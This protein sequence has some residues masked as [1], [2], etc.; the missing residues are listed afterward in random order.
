[1]EGKTLDQLL[2]DVTLGIA[3]LAVIA[4][5]KSEADA[6]RTNSLCCIDYSATDQKFKLFR[7]KLKSSL[8][9]LVQHAQEP[10]NEL[11]QSMSTVRIGKLTGEVPR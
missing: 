10:T 8:K 6:N 3:N 1:M 4:P 11:I 2:D 7:D 5:H 9:E